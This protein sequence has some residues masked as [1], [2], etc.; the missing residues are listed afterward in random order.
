VNTPLAEGPTGFLSRPNVDTLLRASGISRFSISSPPVIVSL[1]ACAM[2]AALEFLVLALGT[3]NLGL[4]TAAVAAFGGVLFAAL[5]AAGA[6][7]NFFRQIGGTI[8]LGRCAL[9]AATDMGVILLFS[10]FGVLVPSPTGDLW[11]WA[12]LVAVAF[13]VSVNMLVLGATSDPRLTHTLVPSLVLPVIL[14]TARVQEADV[15]RGFEAGADDYIKKPFSPQEL[16]ARVQS[17]LGRR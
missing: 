17:I 6:T 14:L 9:L 4:V 11:K 15:T 8:T 5:A 13:S 2:I 3:S 10:F 12:I 7:F 1:L 16:R